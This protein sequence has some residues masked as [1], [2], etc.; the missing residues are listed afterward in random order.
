MKHFSLSPHNL[1]YSIH[2]EMM[3]SILIDHE[4]SFLSY[5]RDSFPVP[6]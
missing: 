3:S 1:T 2:C 4:F 6:Q 5:E